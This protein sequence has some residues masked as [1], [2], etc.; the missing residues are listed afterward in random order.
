MPILTDDKEERKMQIKMR[1]IELQI[2]E[3]DDE[4][5]MYMIQRAEYELNRRYEKR[6]Y[7]K[8]SRK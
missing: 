7:G 8:H 6:V 4:L 1:K 5:I 3:L 2:Q